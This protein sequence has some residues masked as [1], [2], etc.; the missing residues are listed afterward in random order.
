MSG[1]SHFQTG[2]HFHVLRV[3]PQDE[4]NSNSLAQLMQ[5]TC[6]SHFLTNEPAI[7]SVSPLLCNI[8]VD[9]ELAI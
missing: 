9:R 6:V 4:V 1:T 5:D 3:V 2:V 8:F 7:F